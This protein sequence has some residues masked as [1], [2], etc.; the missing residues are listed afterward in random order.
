MYYLG[1]IY[2]YIDYLGHVWDINSQVST[3]IFWPLKNYFPICDHCADAVKTPHVSRKAYLR[4]T[5]IDRV[6]FIITWRRISDIE[7]ISEFRCPVPS[8]WESII[9]CLLVSNLT[10]LAALL[11]PF[12]QSQTSGAISSEWEFNIA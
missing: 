12:K 8:D 5:N 7:G 10:L 3:I 1:T 6:D 4:L 2:T 11:R 9:D